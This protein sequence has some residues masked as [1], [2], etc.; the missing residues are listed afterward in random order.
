LLSFDQMLGLG[1]AKIKWQPL[2]EKIQKLVS[3]REAARE[4]KDFTASDKLRDE[5]KKLGFEID[6][7]KEGAKVRPKLV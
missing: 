7:T 3:E 1:L 6:D 5:I 2:P 4:K